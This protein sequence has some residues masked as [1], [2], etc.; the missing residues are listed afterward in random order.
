MQAGDPDT[1][2]NGCMFKDYN[3]IFYNNEMGVFYVY[4]FLD[5]FNRDGSLKYLKIKDEQKKMFNMITDPSYLLQTEGK[6]LTLDPVYFD[7]DDRQQRS[8]LLMRYDKSIVNDPETGERHEKIALK[9]M[10][11]LTSLEKEISQ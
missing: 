6:E 5:Q 2:L 1:E 7:C 11:I 9:S 4:Y 10:S 8:K 3:N